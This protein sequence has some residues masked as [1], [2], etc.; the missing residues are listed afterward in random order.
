MARKKTPLSQRIFEVT[1]LSLAEYCS[2][3][4]HCQF[5]AFAYRVRLNRL[6][7]NEVIFLCLHLNTPCVELFGVPF[8]D[9]MVSYG[10]PGMAEVRLQIEGMEKESPHLLQLLGFPQTHHERAKE[11]GVDIPTPESVEENGITADNLFE[12]FSGHR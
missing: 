8:L 3:Y 9:L 11:N 7:P 10:Q 12:D 4:L 2:K 1:K 6:Y 5:K